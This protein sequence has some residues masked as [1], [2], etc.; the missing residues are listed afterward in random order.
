[1]GRIQKKKDPDKR[2]L[3]RLERA[4]AVEGGSE[5]ENGDRVKPASVIRKAPI[6][7]KSK[8]PGAEIGFVQKSIQFLREVKIE[9]K[10]VTWPS[11][12][13]TMGSTLV[14]IILVMIISFFLGVV[15][16]G[17]SSLIQTVLP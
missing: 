9:L 4:N 10:K 17:L 13:Q 2:K 6:P 15:D 5:S 14:V 8:I 16:F 11:R 1:M 7:V 3:Q 12:K